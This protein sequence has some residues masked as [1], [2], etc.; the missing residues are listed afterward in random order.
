MLMSTCRLHPEQRGSG[1][2]GWS[3][4]WSGKLQRCGGWHTTGS[5][6]QS[7]AMYPAE[8]PCADAGRE[9]PLRTGYWLCQKMPSHTRQST[10]HR[11]QVGVVGAEAMVSQC[12]V[13]AAAG[14]QMKAAIRG[15]IRA[16]CWLSGLRCHYLQ[17]CRACDAPALPACVLDASSKQTL[18][19]QRL[20]TSPARAAV[21]P[22]P[23]M[24]LRVV[25][26]AQG[27]PA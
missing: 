18:R 11:R 13:A 22:A 21:L 2:R 6:R 12:L 1:G 27:V 7:G 16:V 8:A 20:S 25:C 26:M 24:P 10:T 15:R 17:Q 3:S 4:T 14:A 9:G 5:G 23:R 19:R